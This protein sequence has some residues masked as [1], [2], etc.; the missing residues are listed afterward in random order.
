ME[1]HVPDA[2]WIGGDMVHNLVGLEI[3]SSIG[4]VEVAETE[5]VVIPLIGVFQDQVR[6]FECGRVAQARS[7]EG[8]GPRSE[9]RRPR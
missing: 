8:D 7:G 1:P 5:Q 6:E 4:L 9:S 3:G 2:V